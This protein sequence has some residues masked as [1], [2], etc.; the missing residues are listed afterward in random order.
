MRQHLLA[1]LPLLIVL[2]S[3]QHTGS[4]GA[5]GYVE[6]SESD[7]S[8][9]T[10][11]VLIGMPSPPGLVLFYAGKVE[12]GHFNESIWTRATYAGMGEDGYVLFKAPAG[13]TIAMTD[14]KVDGFHRYVTQK[15]T[16]IPVFTV[17]PGIVLYATDI[18]TVPTKDALQLTYSRNLEAARAY[19][20]THHA[21]LAAKLQAGT[22]QTMRL[23][24]N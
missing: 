8:D 15:D 17:Q 6:P 22:F 24:V 18:L 1:V 19:M 5:W 4:P 2:A 13:A 21:P 12:D 20:S 14:I 3:C 7:V 23:E 16:K 9:K 11:Y 10:G